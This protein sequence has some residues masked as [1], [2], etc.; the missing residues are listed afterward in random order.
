MIADI[1]N[2]RY[3]QF[4][5][6]QEISTVLASGLIKNLNERRIID[7]P[8]GDGIIS[9]WLRKRFPDLRLE[10][11]DIDKSLVETAQRN[12]KNVV[13]EAESVFDL[14]L[15]GNDNI[16]LLV[17]SL[18]CLPDKEKLLAH[19]RPEVEYI[20]AVFPHIDHINYKT[21]LKN[22]PG[23]V[24][25]GA[26]SQAMT[27][28]LFLAH[29]FKHILLK[30]VTHIPHFTLNKVRMGGLTKRILNILDPLFKSKNGSY[31]L[32]VFE[33]Q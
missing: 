28:D 9:F 23:F 29:G 19:F 21:F 8:C 22:N 26:M 32:A 6:A 15:E 16:W 1:F 31:W 4:I 10:L 13:V 18:Y 2:Y 30:D 11:Y 7:A 5:W 33:K 14:V 24:N 12:I 25:P 27:I 3:P 17:N 20:I